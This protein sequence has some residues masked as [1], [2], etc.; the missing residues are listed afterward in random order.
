MF[1]TIQSDLEYSGS[2]NPDGNL[3]QFLVP[4]PIFLLDQLT[5]NS[6]LGLKDN[7][8]MYHSPKHILSPYYATGTRNKK[9][10]K[11]TK[12][13]LLIRNF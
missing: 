5:V 10:S 9:T 6:S 4:L 12:K 3:I 11:E 1:L 13:F 2:N 7:P 8:F